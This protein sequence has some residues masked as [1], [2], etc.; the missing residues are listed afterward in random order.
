MTRILLSG[1][2]GTNINNTRKYIVREGQKY[3]NYEMKIFKKTIKPLKKIKT[4]IFL[5]YNYY[6]KWQVV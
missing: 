4:T 6:F 1:Y 3:N 5:S 2:G